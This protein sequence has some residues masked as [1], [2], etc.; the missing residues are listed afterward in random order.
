[1]TRRLPNQLSGLMMVCTGFKIRPE[2]R[3]L[4]GVLTSAPQPGWLTRVPRHLH[5]H[6]AHAVG[7]QTAGVAERIV[8]TLNLN[9]PTDDD[10]LASLRAD[11][12][13][14]S[15]EAAPTPCDAPVCMLTGQRD[16]VVGSANLAGA[17]GSFDHGTHTNISNAGH[18]LP[19]EQPA[20]FAAVTRSWLAQCRNHLDAHSA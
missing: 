16:R 11:G 14:L 12:F 5:Q 1:V 15:D 8:A 2:D 7:A 9:G 4:T 3:D 19:L 20:I 10:Y 6:F 13:A 17:L 18:Y